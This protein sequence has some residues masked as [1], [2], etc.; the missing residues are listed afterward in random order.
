VGTA[1]VSSRSAEDVRRVVEAVRPDCVVVELCRSRQATMYAPLDGGGTD[2]AAAGIQDLTPPS[3][4]AP[5]P[6][7]FNLSGG[8]LLGA[9]GRSL[10]LGGTGALLLRLALG[11]V[12]SRMSAAAGVRGGTDFVAA[13]EAAEAVGAQLVLG[14]RPVEITLK[15]AWDALPPR[16]RLQLGSR[17]LA[18]VWA[19]AGGGGSNSRRP[20]A[21]ELQEVVEL[22]KEDAAVDAVFRSMGI[23]YPEVVSPLV[24]ERDLYLAWS[25]KRSKA[26]NGTRRVVGVVGKGHLRG[27]SWALTS[28]A[29]GQGLR[30]R[31]LVGGREA[32]KAEG[33]KAAA[34]FLVETAVFAGLWYAWKAL[35]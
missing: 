13:R 8:G 16:R 26:V 20:M 17:L 9:Y 19:L 35:G 23:A 14:D 31:D 33:A 24:H 2:A 30:F 32:R 18:D 29:A 25:L 28:D 12:Y 10:Q 34:R 4:Q 1:H 7:A 3:L 15:R 11:G 22:L 6:N 27:V 21:E 5:A